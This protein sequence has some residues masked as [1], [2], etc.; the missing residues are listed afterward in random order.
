MKRLSLVIPFA[1]CLL[2]L[3]MPAAG[4]GGPVPKIT[5]GVSFNVF[6]CDPTTHDCSATAS[7]NGQ[8]LSPIAGYDK[9]ELNYQDAEGS[10][11]VK[12]DTVIID[13][14]NPN[15]GALTG[16]VIMSSH[17]G[18]EIGKRPYFWVWDRATPGNAGPR[19]DLIAADK[20]DV[21]VTSGDLK[22][23]SYELACP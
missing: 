15:A 19:P 1:L 12:I 2:T 21:S 4:A 9:G 23:H 22:V 16:P 7:F 18:F 13:C 17:P 3:A 11:K 6:G 8:D 10:F 5:G 20:A 14:D